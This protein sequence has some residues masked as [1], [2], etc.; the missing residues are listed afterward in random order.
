MALINYVDKTGLAFFYKQ[1]KRKI[2]EHGMG[3]VDITEEELIPQ[4]DSTGG[5]VYYVDTTNTTI[6]SSDTYTN[7]IPASVT[8]DD[9]FILNQC[10]EFENGKIVN[11]YILFDENAIFV[12][13]IVVSAAGVTTIGSWEKLG[14]DPADYLVEVTQAQYD[15]LPAAQKNN[16]TVY[17]ITDAADNFLVSITDVM[18]TVT[19]AQYDALSESEKNNGKIYFIEDADADDVYA[20]VAGV[21]ISQ[22]TYDALSSAEKNNNVLYLITD[23]DSGVLTIPEIIDTMTHKG[24]TT[25][26]NLPSAGSATGDYYYLTDKLE[27]RYWTGSQWKVVK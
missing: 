13:K 18:L 20:S 12:G 8:G 23:S 17:F 1:I 15:A 9:I 4:L 11:A 24:E 27:G 3:V 16:G 7:R 22:A 19:Q 21:E 14:E 6:P 5:S 10:T 25:L 26:A 2:N